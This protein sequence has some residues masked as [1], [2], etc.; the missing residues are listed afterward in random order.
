MA[1][2]MPLWP[3]LMAMLYEALL[4]FGVLFVAALPFVRLTDY[5]RHPELLNVFRAYLYVIIGVYFCYFWSRSGQTPAMRTWKIRL[6]TRDGK[7]VPPLAR[8]VARYLMAW[9]GWLSGITL[10]W[11]FLDSEGQFLHDR[12]SGL[13]LIR[14]GAPSTSPVQTPGPEKRDQGPAC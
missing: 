5:P 12:L 11:T 8:C 10:I 1:H 3:R 14:H 4:L 13:R 2:R 6:V 9:P 7:Q